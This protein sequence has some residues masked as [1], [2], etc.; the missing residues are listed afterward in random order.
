LLLLYTDGIAETRNAAGEELG[1]ARLFEW[2]QQLP[3]SSAADAG[4]ALV[5]ALRAFAEGAP[6]H[7]DETLIVLERRV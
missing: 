3:T 2:A 6:A 5:A 1:R 4:Q 7:D